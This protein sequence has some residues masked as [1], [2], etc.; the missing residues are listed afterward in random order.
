[1]QYAAQKS[2]VFPSAA[3]FSQKQRVFLLASF[4]TSG[5]VF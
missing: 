1:M 2:D 3:E 5:A 4:R